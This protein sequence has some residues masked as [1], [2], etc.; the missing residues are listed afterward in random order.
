[1]T[2]TRKVAV[3]V[4]LGLVDTSVWTSTVTAAIDISERTQSSLMVLFSGPDADEAAALLNT[5]TLRRLVVAGPEHQVPA[6][7]PQDHAEQF[8]AAL[9]TVGLRSGAL[10]LLPPGAL[11]EEVGGHIAG[12]LGAGHLGNCA[13]IDFDETSIRA[14]RACYGGR[15]MLEVRATGALAVASLRGSGEQRLPFGGEAAPVEYVS[16]PPSSGNVVHVQRF[17]L[18]N[19]QRKLETAQVIVS[20]GRG[21][22]GADQFAAL[23]ELAGLLGGAVGASLPAVDAGWSSVASQVGQSGKF[24]SPELYVAVG[25]SGTPQ[26]MAGISTATR[27]VAINSDAAAEIFRYSEI[28]IVGDYKEVLPKLIEALTTA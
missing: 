4:P 17:A 10:I 26:H 8:V 9:Q 28:G 24:V 22:G 21:I 13:S 11:A 15:A 25:I 5:A 20:G 27:L 12:T 16:V 14:T 3:L 7:L 23:S 2:D 19:Q 6:E 18:E 1:M